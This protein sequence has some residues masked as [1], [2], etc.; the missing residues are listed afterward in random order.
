MTT[1][2]AAM[3]NAVLLARSFFSGR[4]SG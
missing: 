2:L 3:S 1:M 4:S